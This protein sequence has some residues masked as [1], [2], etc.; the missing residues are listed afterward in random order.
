MNHGIACMLS[1]FA[2]GTGWGGQGSSLVG[3][4]HRLTGT[5][6]SSAKANFYLNFGYPMKINRL[7]YQNQ[8]RSVLPRHLRELEHI[9]ER[10]GFVK[11]S[12]G[13]T[14]ERTY[15]CLHQS[16]GHGKRRQSLTL[17]RRAKWEG[18]KQQTTSGIIGSWDLIIREKKKTVMAAKWWDTSSR[19]V[20]ETQN[21]I[22][23]PSTCSSS[24][25]F[26]VLSNCMVLSFFD[27]RIYVL[28]TDNQPRKAASYTEIG[29]KLLAIS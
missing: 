3:C 15:C 19:G 20:M 29:K 25:C 7:I 4:K 12:E 2:E 28:H 21:L 1:R 5:S 18:K 9:Q 24:M 6:G 10:T 8:P 17:L 11:P 23:P 13:K 27:F 22:S 26:E 14:T 16:N